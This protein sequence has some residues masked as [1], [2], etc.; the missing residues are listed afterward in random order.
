MGEEIDDFDTYLE[1]HG[2]GEYK[3][4]LSDYED[5]IRERMETKNVSAKTTLAGALYDAKR[6]EM[7]QY[8]VASLA[9]TTETSI[10]SA[11]EA[12]GLD[13]DQGLNELMQVVP[14]AQ[15]PL[16][17]D[18]VTDTIGE[19]PEA[20]AAVIHTEVL[21]KQVEEAAE[22]FGVTEDEVER[23][24][25]WLEENRDDEELTFDAVRRHLDEVRQEPA[26]FKELLEEP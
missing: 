8:E 10:R 12:M 23:A 20:V 24:S 6:D 13:T 19:P 26:A 1:E 11:R 7:T 4:V 21:G 2:F 15:A 9:E 5:L 22:Y 3:D 14:Y 16:L 25:S 18:Y 17:D